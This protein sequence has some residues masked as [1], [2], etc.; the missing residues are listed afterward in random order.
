M[1]DALLAG[2]PV[3]ATRANVDVRSSPT[4]LAAFGAP[5]VGVVG[6]V[7]SH[8]VAF[9][10]RRIAQLRQQRA[11]TVTQ[12]GTVALAALADVGDARAFLRAELG[13][14]LGDDDKSSR[15][16]ATLGAYLE[17]NTSPSR[18]SRR[19]DVHENTITDRIMA[20]QELVPHPIE[21]RAGEL[22]VAAIDWAGS[23]RVTVAV[24]FTGW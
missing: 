22:H 11:G 21:R 14:L 15:L 23:E 6:F 4:V 17:E 10:A 9:D 3:A 19:L 13:Q 8:R 1:I 12:Y 2:E 18:A 5:A 20:A 16:S 24:S 7:R